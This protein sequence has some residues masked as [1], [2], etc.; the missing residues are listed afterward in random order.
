MSVRACLQ[1]GCKYFSPKMQADVADAAQRS[2][3]RST[4]G[5]HHEGR[6]VLLCSILNARVM[7]H[8]HFLC[9]TEADS[10]AKSDARQTGWRTLLRFAAHTH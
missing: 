3:I 2:R 9:S 4:L 5:H 1:P 7:L 6:G 8:S 10:V